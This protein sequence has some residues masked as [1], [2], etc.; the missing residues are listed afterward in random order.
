MLF[1]FSTD[2]RMKPEINNLQRCNRKGGH[3]YEH[4]RTHRRNAEKIR[5]ALAE[6]YVMETKFGGADGLVEHH[7]TASIGIVL[8]V[9]HIMPLEEIMRRADAAMYL[10]K[11]AGRNTVYFMPTVNSA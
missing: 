4:T 11:D 3:V 10:A 9:N 8:F 6:P 7:C 1:N 2:N 5:A